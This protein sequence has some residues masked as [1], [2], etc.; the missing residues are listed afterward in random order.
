MASP[1]D[2]SHELPVLAPE[3]PDGL[4]SLTPV[5]LM[6]GAHHLARSYLMAFIRLRM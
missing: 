3:V 6:Y 4:K 2:S 5:R 1:E